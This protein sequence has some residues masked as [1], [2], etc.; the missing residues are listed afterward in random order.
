MSGEI[1]GTRRYTAT[2]ALGVSAR[3]CDVEWGWASDSTSEDIPLDSV[4][5][6][7]LDRD[8]AGEWL[9]ANDPRLRLDG[10]ASEMGA[11]LESEGL[12]MGEAK[13][14]FR[15]AG[16]R[17]T[18]ALVGLR[19]RVCRAL[20]PMWDDDRRRDYMAQALGCD[21]TTLWRLMA[22]PQHNT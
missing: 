6:S 2:E 1:P 8:A 22:K 3:R 18:K 13:G 4:F 16:G 7:Q 17:P 14:A 11:A 15:K 9:R 12:T 10:V 19:S 20:L 21:R 5:G